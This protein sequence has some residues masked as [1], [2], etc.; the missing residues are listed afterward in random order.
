MLAVLVLISMD[1][2]AQ[3]RLHANANY[4]FDDRID[5]YFDAN[6]FYNGKIR[7]GFQWGGALEYMIKPQYGIELSYYRQDAVA[8][9]KTTKYPLQNHDFDLAINYIFLSGSRYIRKPGGKV[10]GFGGMGLGMA[11]INAKDPATGKTS[12]STN[13]A[14]QLR[15]GAIIW[16]SE[17]IGIKLQAQLQSAVQA[18][19][20]GV[21]FGTGGAGAGVS[22]FSSVV[23]FGLGGGLV[24][25][26]AKK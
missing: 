4:V 14:W 18:V 25:N 10:E 20:G 15:G 19:G 22:T 5:S 16:G 3:I 9:L 24:F 13:F 2:A 8:P 12:N 21:F 6:N 17:K 26:I 23:Q 11:I 1:A 7:G